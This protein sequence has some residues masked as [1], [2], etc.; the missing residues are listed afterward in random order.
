[1]FIALIIVISIG[2]S[3][4]NMKKGKLMQK[5]EKLK[6]S[7]SSACAVKRCVV[8]LK[9][10]A[11]YVLDTVWAIGI[12]VAATMATPSPIHLGSST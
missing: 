4:T 9:I 10:A 6:K 1:V 8:K 7:K 5:H 2:Q 11:I 12:S 3:A